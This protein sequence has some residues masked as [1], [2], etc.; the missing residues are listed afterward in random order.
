MIF[1]RSYLKQPTF[2]FVAKLIIELRIYVQKPQTG[3]EKKMEHFFVLLA[4]R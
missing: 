3:K 1:S 2:S 4:V